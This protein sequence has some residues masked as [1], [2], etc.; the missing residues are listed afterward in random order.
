VLTYFIFMKPFCRSAHV[1]NYKCGAE[2]NF[3]VSTSN[4]Y[5]HRWQDMEFHYWV[6]NILRRQKFIHPGM[7]LIT[8]ARIY[9][10]RRETYYTGTNSYTWVWNLLRRHKLIHLGVKLITQAQIYTPGRETYYTG[11]NLYTRAWNLLRMHKLIHLGVKLITQAWTYTPG[12][13]TYY[14]GMN[15]YT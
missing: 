2:R 14:L 9:T 11:T 10:P 13:E 4:E 7:Q 1:C 15:L 12:R 8:R 3:V 6:W 5:I